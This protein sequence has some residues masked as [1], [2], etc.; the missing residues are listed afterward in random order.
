MA[1]IGS[2]LREARMRAHLD[3]TDF[4][5]RTKIRAKYLRALEDE[6]WSLLPGYTYTKGFLRTYADMLGLDERDRLL[7]QGI[8]VGIEAVLAG[9][10][11]LLGL[12]VLQ[13]LGL[14][15]GLALAAP[16]V[17]ERGDLGLVDVGALDALGR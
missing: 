10:L 12:D 17:G 6:E 7:Q 13:Q 14:E 3:I 1:G 5:A 11:R 16:E 15:L 4:E 2:T 8:L 9:A